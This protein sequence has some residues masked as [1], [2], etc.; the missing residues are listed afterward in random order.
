MDSLKDYWNDKGRLFCE[1]NDS[2]NKNFANNAKRKIIGEV[3]SSL[4]KNNSKE[5]EWF[6]K[7]LEDES[8]KWFAVEVFKKKK[9]LP[10]KLFLSFVKAAI[11]EEDISL[12]RNF[13]SP[14]VKTFGAAEVSKC[15]NFYIENGESLEKKGAIELKYWVDKLSL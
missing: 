3:C 4:P 11:Y 5:L 7:A 12:N 9:A 6:A 15:L 14:C 2:P 1:L 8:L 10:K 13:I